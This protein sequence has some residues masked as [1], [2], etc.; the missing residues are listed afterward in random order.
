MA[1]AVYW[2][3][4]VSSGRFFSGWTA[5]TSVIVAV[6]VLSPINELHSVGPYV[7][8]M[9]ASLVAWLLLVVA[10]VPAAWAERR[11]RSAAARGAVVIAALVAVSITRPF[12]NDA[13]AAILFDHPYT[14]GWLQRIA[15]NAFTWLTLLPLVALAA[16]R[17]AAARESAE[18]LAAALGVFDELRA[19]VS[20]YAAHNAE[21]LDVVVSD[22]RQRR[23]ALLAGTVDF[24]A[25]RAFADHVRAVSHRLDERLGTPLHAGDEGEE[26]SVAAAR[27]PFFARLARPNAVLV[28]AL[29]IVASL[30]YSFAVG[31]V[32]LVLAALGVLLLF[33][34]VAD[35]VIRWAVRGR[36]P[37]V[38][39]VIVLVTWIAVGIAMFG[40]GSLLTGADTAVLVIPLVTIPA[41]AVV[42][43]LTVD[44]LHRARELSRSLTELLARTSTLATVQTARAR[45]PL[46]RAVDLLHDRVQSRCVIFAARVDERPPTADEVEAFRAETDQAFSEILCGE[47]PA[48][49]ADL[50]GILA[51]W[52]GILDVQAEV[53]PI[54]AATLQR[55]EVAAEVV[56]VVSEGF[57]N[58][59]K[60]SGAREVRLAV[61]TS[62]DETYLTVSVRSLGILHVLGR[63]AGLGL[64]SFGG[65]ARLRQDGD[66]VVLEVAVSTGAVHTVDDD[67]RPWRPPTTAIRLPSS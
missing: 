62:A 32:P 59:V 65:R 12:L 47:G 22:V 67:Q 16:S 8:A 57:V 44:A 53:D 19:R 9:V 28:L 50:D 46:W 13:V 66:D 7:A 2:W 27:V 31:G 1:V 29:Y 24:D 21:L 5:L 26:P 25:V 45:E 36:S 30:P 64:A 4:A 14:A 51:T 11:L 35:T 23:D 17:Y 41:L 55:P 39:G 48:E 40:A 18:R 3:E 58:A 33:S 63:A 10:V 42:V 20:R 6:G 56:A 61:E 49:A 34:I 60:H 43:G 38:R 52:S 37:V 54:A 15:T